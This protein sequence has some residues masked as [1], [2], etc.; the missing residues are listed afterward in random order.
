MLFCAKSGGYIYDQ[1]VRSTPLMAR[2]GAPS[3]RLH[4]A[5]Y[6][7]NC[8]QS[9]YPWF[10]RLLVFDRAGPAAPVLRWLPGSRSFG[11]FPILTVDLYSLTRGCWGGDP[12]RDGARIQ[13]YSVAQATY[14]MLAVPGLG[15]L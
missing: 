1:A 2:I 6:M 7:L 14:S 15:G 12:G 3:Y 4:R 11:R 8:C 9:Q 5:P 13:R 10:V